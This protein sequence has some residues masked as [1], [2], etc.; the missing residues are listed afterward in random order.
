[1]RT[2]KHRHTCHTSC[3]SHTGHRNTGEGRVIQ[4]HRCGRCLLEARLA[5]RGGARGCGGPRRSTWRLGSAVDAVPQDGR[6]GKTRTTR[7]R[8][9]RLD[10]R[11][12][13]VKG[14]GPEVRGPAGGPL[15]AT[16]CHAGEPRSG[17]ERPRQAPSRAERRAERTRTAGR[18]LRTSQVGRLR[19]EMS[20]G[21]GGGCSGKEGRTTRQPTEQPD[22][23]PKSGLPPAK[24]A[25][26]VACPASPCGS[27][28][29]S[30][31]PTGAFIALA[32][33]PLDHTPGTLWGAPSTAGGRGGGELSDVQ[34]KPR[35][36]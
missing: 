25:C 28:C 14:R 18:R 7:T 30:L 11:S 1:M 29:F 23:L 2:N 19:E 24:A 15:R 12:C 17:P 10:W 31:G 26:A 6:R 32:A 33:W 5:G 35:L 27:A 36:R 4:K 16:L 20:G 9:G 3:H 21:G 13:T 34:A 8:R 22:A